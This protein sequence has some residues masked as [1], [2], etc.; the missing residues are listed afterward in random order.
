M[1]NRR[2]SPQACSRRENLTRVAPTAGKQVVGPWVRPTARPA[3]AAMVVLSNSSKTPR[4]PCPAPLAGEESFSRRSSWAPGE[5]PSGQ[6]QPLPARVLPGIKKVENPFR[7]SATRWWCS[8][9]RNRLL[10]RKNGRPHTT[11]RTFFDVI[12]P[13]SRPGTAANTVVP[14]LSREVWTDW[15]NPGTAGT[16]MRW[17][18]SAWIDESM[19]PRWRK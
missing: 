15:N 9:R 5:G 13:D 2:G 18:S 8:P 7:T 14:S 3:S 10:E 12:N 6:H 16:V 17:K 4:T 1:P 11:S 19:P